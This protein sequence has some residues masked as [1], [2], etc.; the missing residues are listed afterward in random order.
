M[1]VLYLPTSFV[2]QVARVISLSNESD[3]AS[4]R[5]YL[6]SRSSTSIQHFDLAHIPSFPLVSS[7]PFSRHTDLLAFK[8]ARHCLGLRP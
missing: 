4:N 5:L 3:Q 6:Q 7:C 8:Q 1:C 2:T